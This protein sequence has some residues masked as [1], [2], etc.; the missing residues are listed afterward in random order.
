[1]IYYLNISMESIRFAQTN[2]KLVNDTNMKSII[3][4]KIK[5]LTN[6]YINNKN[7]KYLNNNTKKIVFDNIKNYQFIPVSFGKKF[8]LFLTK[9][10]N[11]KYTF[12]INKKKKDL[13]II[14]MELSDDLYD[15]T[16][17]DGELYK[18][19][20]KWVF[21]INDILIYNN[22]NYRFKSLN[23]RLQVLNDIFQENYDFDTFKIVLVKYYTLNYFIDFIENKNKIFDYKISG[24]LFKNNNDTNNYLYIF[25]ENRT[26]SKKIILDVEK[27]DLPDI[28]KLYCKKNNKI[29]EHS[30]A[31]IPNLEISQNLKVLFSNTKSKL[32]F[33]CNFN[34]NFNKYVPIKLSDNDLTELKI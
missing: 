18:N 5:N 9:I 23:N 30:I 3:R 17:F 14:D 33:E 27:T 15:N 22:I 28:Y 16:L 6:I 10:E 25:E 34:K 31:A 26:K 24:V 13:I 1:M 11:K 20:N 32:R 7:Y 2:A 21:Q 4:A 19:N 8:M 29:V 12:M